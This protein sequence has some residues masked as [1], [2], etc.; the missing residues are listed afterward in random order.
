MMTNPNNL[1]DKRIMMLPNM[2]EM[3]RCSCNAISHTFW[4][5]SPCRFGLHSLNVCKKVNEYK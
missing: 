3:Q 5:Q 4:M 2:E 1:V